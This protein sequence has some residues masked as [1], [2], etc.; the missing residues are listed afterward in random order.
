MDGSGGRFEKQAAHCRVRGLL[1]RVQAGQGHSGRA[2][3][4]GVVVLLVL[5]G[6]ERSR[7][8]NDGDWTAEDRPGLNTV[9]FGI[10]ATFFDC[11]TVTFDG[12][13]TEGE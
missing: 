3:E 12:P 11:K 5:Y 6:A 9:A 10:F 8:L 13:G 1:S 2:E 4:A 7:D